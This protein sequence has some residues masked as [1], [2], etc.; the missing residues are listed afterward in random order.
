[1]KTKLRFLGILLTLCM[2]LTLVPMAAF[3][4][5]PA[6]VLVNGADITQATDYTVACG[7]G[8]AVYDP[9]AH[10]LT[11][12]DA[13][14]STSGTISGV[15]TAY[16]VANEELTILLKGQNTINEGGSSS[17]YSIV[18][19]K[20][21]TVQGIDNGTLTAVGKV[22]SNSGDIAIAD[23]QVSVTTDQAHGI[24]AETG[25]LSIQ[26][27]TVTAI[28]KY[29]GLYAQQNISINQST[30]NATTAEDGY[31]GVMSYGKTEII[32]S[33]VMAEGT[34]T[35]G[36]YSALPLTIEGGT[37][38]AKGLMAICGPGASISQT[39]LNLTGDMTG[40]SMSTTD[41]YGDLT[42]SNSLLSVKASEAAVLG[43]TVL[44][45]NCTGSIE[46]SKS[47]GIFAQKGLAVTGSNT[48]L[49]VIGRNG[50]NC[51]EDMTVE[52]G[53]LSIVA[54]GTNSL[55][56]IGIDVEGV[57][58]FNAGELYAKGTSK[59]IIAEVYSDQVDMGNAPSDIPKPIVIDRRYAEVNGA[60]LAGSGWVV[61]HTSEGDIWGYKASFISASDATGILAE[62]T[63]N[64]AK[65]ITIKIK[66]PDYTAPSGGTGSGGTVYTIFFSGNEG[67]RIIPEEN[68]AVWEGKELFV[69]E[70]EDT[71]LTVV[72]EEGYELDKVLI[73]GQMVTL[74]QD[75]TYRF[76][77]VYESHIFE[78]YFKKMNVI[79]PEI[80]TK[81]P[82]T[83]DS[84]N[85]VLLIILLFIS[86]IALIGASAHLRK[87]R[88]GK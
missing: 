37:V 68:S 47:D 57:F 7:G 19:S 45:D 61:E 69:Q 75:N 34:T 11:L 29:Y 2:V 85:L 10:T 24:Y 39:E 14:I 26:K 9:A 76:E 43:G 15:G 13:T 56:G 18:A 21:L 28:G 8:T 66:T 60:K 50:I 23:T 48:D 22:D 86:G 40:I 17:N 78:A 31:V 51:E 52:G 49:T 64:A 16:I 54:N 71:V 27:A 33:D 20:G 63:S 3:A 74:T 53:K 79:N 1:M 84:Q 72:P 81:N 62:D 46:S 59:A 30:V 77:N 12:E 80:I 88:Y 73:D 44:L 5:E 38:T 36:I 55:N 83:G 42:I 35:S 32:S 25:S 67:G 87:K 4:A 58:Y 6:Q 82:Q 70:G 65:E 41:A